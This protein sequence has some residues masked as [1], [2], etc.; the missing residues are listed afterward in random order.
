MGYLYFVWSYRNCRVIPVMVRLDRE[1]LVA[2]M[3]VK[4][5]YKSVMLSDLLKHGKTTMKRSAKVVDI[6]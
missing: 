3:E 5:W 2:G 1:G 4:K 6:L